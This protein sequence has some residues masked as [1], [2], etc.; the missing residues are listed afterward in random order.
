MEREQW[1]ELMRA[2]NDVA[3]GRTDNAYHRHPSVLIVRVYLWAALHD[4]PVSWACRR[5]AWDD[6]TR[7]K[8]LP[9]QPTMRTGTVR[10]LFDRLSARMAGRATTRLVKQVDGKP[11]PV[12]RHSQDGQAAW[13]RGAG[14]YARGY[15][16]HLIDAGGPMPQAFT[17]TPMNHSESAT[18]RQLVEQL[19][20]T[21]Y[22]LGD[23]GYDD[24]KLYAAARRANHKLIAPRRRPRTGLGKGKPSDPD[25]LDAI[26]RLERA[27]QL[28]NRFGPTLMQLRRRVETTL[29]N[30]TS[31]GTGLTHL[32]PWVRGLQRV[33]LYVH[34]KLLI[35][36]ARIRG[37]RE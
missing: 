10:R 21:G 22:L 11:I 2:L 19:T 12:S 5:S 20:G 23:A 25:R 34:A 29:G 33:S 17:V 37:L 24:S 31:H 6:R 36:A 35:N 4:R 26:D 14:A 16:L 1:A 3:R 32:P 7:P 13:G 27:P 28:G 8:R 9:S 15:K 30:F 18:A